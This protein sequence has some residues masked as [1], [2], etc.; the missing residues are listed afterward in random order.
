MAV[1]YQNSQGHTEI[2]NTESPQTSAKNPK[3]LWIAVM[4]VFEFLSHLD[5]FMKFRAKS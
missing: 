1:I 3:S 4:Y 5:K 2:T